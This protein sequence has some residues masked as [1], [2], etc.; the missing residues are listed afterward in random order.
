MSYSNRLE[1]IIEVLQP[2]KSELK[3]STDEIKYYSTT[4]DNDYYKDFSYHNNETMMSL[5]FTSS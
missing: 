4:E 3:V 5:S 1:E 2:N